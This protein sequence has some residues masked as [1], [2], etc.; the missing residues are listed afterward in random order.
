V[1]GKT[2]F[3]IQQGKRKRKRRQISWGKGKG[4]VGRSKKGMVKGGT[5]AHFAKSLR[6]KR[7]KT[8]P[9]FL[10]LTTRYAQKRE[11]GKQ[12]GGRAKYC[13]K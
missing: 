11:G 2:P 13:L 8:K 4:G 9:Y 1:G 3:F 7:V 5:T 10:K 12:R 6:G